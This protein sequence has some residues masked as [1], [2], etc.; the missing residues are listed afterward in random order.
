MRGESDL[1]VAAR[2]ILLDALDALVQHLDSVVLVGAQAIYLHTGDTDLAVALYTK[3]ADVVLDPTRLRGSPT[4]ETVMR[5]GGFSATGEPGRWLKDEIPI[6]LM[7]P[8]ALAGPGRRGADLGLHGRTVARRARGLEGALVDKRVQ[9]IGSLDR[10]DPRILQVAVAGPGALLTAKLHK[11]AE[12]EGKPGRLQDK[13]ALDVLRLLRA[14]ESE[15]LVERLRLLTS[16]DLARETA[17]ESV[18]F[19]VD[20]FG[21]RKGAGALSA[22]RALEGLQDQDT[23][24]ASCEALVEELIKAGL[25][26][27]T[28]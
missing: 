15:T 12:R 23:V 13:D 6:D 17:Q 26:I 11:I 20:L 25:E 22:A 5:D 1:Y 7:V 10:G 16:S 28:S 19:L 9:A 14:I 21:T 18:R 2:R 4:I 8:E 3:D 24:T 27:P